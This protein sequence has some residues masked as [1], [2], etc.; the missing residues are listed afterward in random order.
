M[1]RQIQKRV[2]VR[3]QQSFETK[4]VANM[5]PCNSPQITPT[6]E[7]PPNF[8]FLRNQSCSFED[9]P[10]DLCEIYKTPTQK[11]VPIDVFGFQ[12]NEEQSMESERR[13]G[14]DLKCRRPSARKLRLQLSKTS[15]R[16]V[17]QQSIQQ[18][19]DNPRYFLRSSSV[20]INEMK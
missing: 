13:D 14:R 5:S 4:P 6:S 12:T 18:R 1:L 16:P 3:R 20:A 17:K 10:M 9:E 8:P 15:S 2:K 19:E 11:A 7:L